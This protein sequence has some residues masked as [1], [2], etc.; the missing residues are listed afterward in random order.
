MIGQRIKEIRTDHKMSQT[1]LA[2]KIKVSQQTIT[3]WETGKAEPSSSAL[4][5][6]AKYFNVSTDYLLGLTDQRKTD[7][8][9]EAD[10]DH[11]INEAR[12]FDGKPISDR[13]RKV[14]K[15]ILRSY[16]KIKALPINNTRQR[17]TK[18]ND[19]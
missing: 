13:D 1:E 9:V 16:F 4:E 12:S 2:A 10:L 14:V 8:Q 11:A 19:I 15:D 18:S 3:K 5:S 6:I 17:K 7:Q